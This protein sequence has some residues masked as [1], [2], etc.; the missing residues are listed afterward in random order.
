MPRNLHVSRLFDWRL[1]GPSTR[2]RAAK[3]FLQ[4]VWRL[5]VVTFSLI[6]SLASALGQAVEYE[7]SSMTIYDAARTI[8][9]S[10]LRS[11]N[12]LDDL[13]KFVAAECKERKLVRL[14]LAAT[15]RELSNVSN[16]ELPPL[17]RASIPDLLRADPSL[18]NPNLERT[19]AAQVFCF[20]GNATVAVRI[21]S[22]VVFHRLRGN[23]DPRGIDLRGRRFML[24]GFRLDMEPQNVAKHD[25]NPLP[26]EL[27][28]FATISALQ[29]LEAAA[30]VRAYIEE[31][32][33]TPTYLFLRT[34]PFFFDYGGPR[35]DAFSPN[36]S[37][38]SVG[39]F[40]ARPYIVC[41]PGSGTGN[42]RLMTSHIESVAKRQR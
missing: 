3:T 41:W 28:I 14:T 30:A 17:R 24:I 37:R 21:G 10:D 5:S 20:G 23:D 33:G 39:E 6:G 25:P 26:A 11:P 35:T 2:T 9:A 8:S 1:E 34:D 16:V 12:L 31:A 4:E 22:N 42:C 15:A 29:G 7:H 40:L 19:N 38:V 27:R 13:S 36:A 18:L 32:T